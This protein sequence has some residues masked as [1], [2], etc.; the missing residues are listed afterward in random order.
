MDNQEGLLGCI[1]IIEDPRVERKKWDTITPMVA[2]MENKIV[3]FT[4]GE[5]NSHIYAFL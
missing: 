1:S 5:P 4:R 3:G 2:L